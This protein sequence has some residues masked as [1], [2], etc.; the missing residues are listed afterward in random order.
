MDDVGGKLS[1]EQA[2][3]AHMCDSS[4]AIEDVISKREYLLLGD[5]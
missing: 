4:W 5:V 2:M 3:V 1:K